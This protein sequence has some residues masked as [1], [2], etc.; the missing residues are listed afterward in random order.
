MPTAQSLV[1]VNTTSTPLTVAVLAIVA[2]Y[3]V[4]FVFVPPRRL[5]AGS[6]NVNVIKSRFG[7]LG[8]IGFFAN[9]YTL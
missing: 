7:G 6:N 1:Q 4:Y 8:A 9:R 5:H 2:T 3:L